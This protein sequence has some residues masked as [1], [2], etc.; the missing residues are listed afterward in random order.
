LGSLALTNPPLRFEEDIR[1][2]WTAVQTRIIDVIASD[3]APHSAEE[4]KARSVWDVKPGFPGFETMLPLL[5]T[6][7]NSGRLTLSAL[8]RLTSEKPCEIFG[9]KGR[10]S[11]TD[12]NY[13]DFTVVDMKKTY[14]IDSSEFYSKAKYSPFDGWRV[15]GR[16]VKTFV[17][18]ELV[19]DEGEIV[20]KP[21]SG[22]IVTWRS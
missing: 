1:A 16:P 5:L 18:G 10:G 22:K 13:A 9:I 21:G 6:Q 15:K 11:L 12:G 20:T 14:E 17:N 3:H 19:M 2:L 4:K 7:V 8:V